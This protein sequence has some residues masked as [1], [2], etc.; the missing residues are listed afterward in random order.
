MIVRHCYCARTMMN[1]AERLRVSFFLISNPRRTYFHLQLSNV[2]IPLM[3]HVGCELDDFFLL[4]DICLLILESLNYLV[5]IGV[6]LNSIINFMKAYSFT[7]IMQRL[8][9][10]SYDWLLSMVQQYK[11][12]IH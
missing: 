2:V 12:F 1:E 8:R 6:K 4:N 3:H 5:N 7:T 11:E 10:N 9:D